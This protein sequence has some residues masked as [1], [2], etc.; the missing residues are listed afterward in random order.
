M[1]TNL[2]SHLQEKA[3]RSHYNTS[4]S[5]ERRGEQMVKD[6][7]EELAND[8]QELQTGGASEESVSDYQQ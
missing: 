5:P 4:F 6:Y 7:G 3:I 8:L 1:Q 2:L